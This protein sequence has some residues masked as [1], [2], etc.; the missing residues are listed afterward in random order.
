MILSKEY[1]DAAFGRN[2]AD[3][4][5]PVSG[6]VNTIKSVQNESAAYGQ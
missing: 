6:L 1:S 2:C 4:P 3:V 5:N